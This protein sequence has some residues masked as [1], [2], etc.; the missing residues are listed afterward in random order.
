MLIKSFKKNNF[1][2]YFL[3]IL[4]G[5][6]C[7][8]LSAQVMGTKKDNQFEAI[9]QHLPHGYTFSDCSNHLHYHAVSTDD[10]DSENDIDEYTEYAESE[11][12][13]KS[14]QQPRLSYIQAI[15]KIISICLSNYTLYKL[16]YN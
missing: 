2:I 11:E 9:R 13:V 15:E 1:F 7:F 12:E 10:A 6:N 8:S 14:T 16:F 4:C 5:I 3:I